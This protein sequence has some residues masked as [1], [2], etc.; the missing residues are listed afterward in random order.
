MQVHWKAG[1]VL[2]LRTLGLYAGSEAHFIQDSGGHGKLLGIY[3]I[4]EGAS[5][6]LPW[7]QSGLPDAG[8]SPSCRNMSPAG[9]R[10]VSP[11]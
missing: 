5:R 8:F 4:V 7:V 3:N 9:I 10:I 11:S 2:A 1:R 6:C